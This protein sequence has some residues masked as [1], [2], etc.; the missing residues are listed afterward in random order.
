MYM[1][2]SNAKTKIP[3]LL[4]EGIFSFIVSAIICF[5]IGCD[6]KSLSLI[7]M[8]SIE[9]G[10]ILLAV[11][12]NKAQQLIVYR[13]GIV[14]K[15]N[16]GSVPED[17]GE[18]KRITKLSN[19]LIALTTKINGIY[20]FPINQADSTVVP[21]H[22]PVEE[23]ALVSKKIRSV[24]YYEFENIRK[25]YV[26]YD[27]PKGSGATEIT[28]KDGLTVDRYNQLDTTSSELRSNNIVQV[29]SDMKG[30][31]W[32]NYS[33]KDEKGLS[34]LN[35][36]GEWVHFDHN[37]SELPDK[38]VRI[39][40]SEGPSNGV[41][42]DNVWFASLSGLTRLEYRPGEKDE[43]D[44]EKWKL[45]GERETTSGII[46]RAIGVRELVS[47]AVLDIIDLHIIDKNLLLANR[48]GVYTFNGKS[49]NRFMPDSIGGLNETQI[50]AINYRDGFVIVKTRPEEKQFQYIDN[51][52]L[53]D[54]KKRK[55][56]KIKHWLIKK[57]YPKDVFFMPYTKGV[58]FVGLTY[59]D[60]T[61]MFAFFNYDTMELKKIEAPLLIPAV[62]PE[63]TPAEAEKTVSE[64]EQAA[65][66]RQ[67]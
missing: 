8:A 26:I 38:Y 2:I 13:Q 16:E 34:R 42:G 53:L 59:L 23:G 9:D 36:K 67:P 44:K 21:V 14:Q 51:L 54:L 52:N 20:L 41:D 37:N 63:T 56:T 64:P 48:K 45:Y 62:Q 7:D 11:K 30:N 22:L 5:S 24:Y 25:L 39:V 55:W 10:T 12:Y 65:P 28:F 32:F 27:T 57:D 15:W 18:I 60:G 61:T 49:M 17:L 31:V 19:S 43:E 35:P 40:R 58:D 3:S 4:R 46:A 50:S 47:D 29:T 6:S 33:K 1:L 66:G